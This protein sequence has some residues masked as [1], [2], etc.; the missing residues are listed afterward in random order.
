MLFDYNECDEQ[1][2]LL[3]AKKMENLSYNDILKQC[4]EYIASY[5]KGLIHNR[6]DEFVCSLKNDKFITTT[7]AKGQLGNFI[8]KY[9]FGYEPNSDQEAD[10]SKV[11]IEIKQTPIDI[12]KQGK[13]RAGER[14]SITMISFNEPV[15]E[16]FYKSHLWNKIQKILLIHYIRDK[17]KDRLDYKIKYVNLFTPPKEDLKIIIEDYY[18]IN[19][20]I[21]AGKAHELS[22]G[23]T[24][25][26]G[27]CTKGATAKSSF[28][29]QYYNPSVEAKRRNFCFKQSYMNYVLNNYIINNNC[30]YESII[31]GI[32]SD[33][34][35]EDYVIN[36]LN[37]YI[38]KTDKELCLMFDR[39]YNGN[40]AQWSDLAYRMLGIR[41]NQAKEFVKA[42][43]VVKSVRLEK[44]GKNKENMSL[45]SF[46]F[47]DL[48]KEN[49][50]DSTLHNYLE[51]TKFLF[52]V[53]KSNGE[54]YEFVGAKLWNMPQNDL[55]VIVKEGW[56]NIKNKLISGVHFNIKPT[57][58]END[59]PKKKNNKIIHIRPHSSKSAFK[60]NNGFIK[61]NVEKDANE[62]PNGEW[63]TTQSFW[64]NNDYILKIIKEQL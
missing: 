20:K 30:P 63:M 6:D 29:P 35:F 64:L 23:D 36:T 42:G 4:K 51:T 18:K 28:K 48:V 32:N 40:K 15:E 10:L 17:S 49:W 12:S 26:L 57:C 45:P 9:Y 7:N 61:G 13:M 33:L 39:E 43:I 62:L 60:L 16:D 25:Y 31:E 54:C 37:Q 58:V 55:E 24:M 44:N 53:Y 2:I 46:K 38:G 34:T 21:K 22:E 56:L 52:V 50:E 27:A 5:E 14:V 47:L 8:E 11:G 59:L 1:S 19:E 3:Y 41:S